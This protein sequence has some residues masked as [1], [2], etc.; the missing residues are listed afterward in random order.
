MARPKG[1]V[2]PVDPEVVFDRS[3][4]L[5]GMRF[6]RV[7]QEYNETYRGFGAGSTLFAQG[8]AA[9]VRAGYGGSRIL[10]PTGSGLH[11]SGFSGFGD[12]SV[13]PGTYGDLAPTPCGYGGGLAG[14]PGALIAQYP[15]AAVAVAFLLGYL[16]KSRR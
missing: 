8:G 4:D 12:M 2:L 6:Q 16:A 3:R 5:D 9:A 11:H 13:M 15:I 10:W 14:G 7:P 1:Y